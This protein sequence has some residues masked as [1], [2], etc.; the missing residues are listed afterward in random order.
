[1]LEYLLQP[2][3]LRIKCQNYEEKR[4]MN[5]HLSNDENN[6]TF[7]RLISPYYQDL[8]KYCSSLTPTAWEAEDL[9]QDTMMKL[10]LALQQQPNRELA[11]RYLYRIAQN[12]WIDQKRKKRIDTESF[13]EYEEYIENIKHPYDFQVRE[14]LEV[15]SQYLSIKQFV[16]VLLMD[17]FQFTAKESAYMIRESEANIH[18]SLHR[19]RKKLKRYVNI[20]LNVETAYKP[21]KAKEESTNHKMDNNSFETFINGF[22]TRDAQLIYKTYL[23]L[24]D[25]G[26]QVAKVK[27]F[28]YSLCFQFKDLDGNIL[29]LCNTP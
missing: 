28:G 20:S 17:V 9:F 29:T 13:D 21:I 2:Y 15:L 3:L 8:K 6:S 4:I 11:K 18:T 14:S 1:M 12:T 10:Y 7:D 24:S 27:T 5:N 16:I 19:S 23:S 22:K 25:K 26:I